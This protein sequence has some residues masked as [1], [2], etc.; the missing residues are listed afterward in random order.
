[1]LI[2][3][4]SQIRGNISD[5]H[6]CDMELIKAFLQG[7]VYCWIK[8]NKEGEIFALRNLVGG[9]NSNWTNTPLKLLYKKHKDM[10]KDNKT[11]NEVAGQDAGKILKLVLN[12]D[13]RKFEVSDAGFTNGYKWIK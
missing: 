7:A 5:I 2:N 1:M 13:E 12:D 10:G 11:A 9:E 4:N 8:N 3:D 6:K